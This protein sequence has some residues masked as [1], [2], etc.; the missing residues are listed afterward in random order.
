MNRSMPNNTGASQTISEIEHRRLLAEQFKASPQAGP[1]NLASQ[2]QQVQR[3]EQFDNLMQTTLNRFGS[4]SVNGSITSGSAAPSMN[5]GP[6]RHQQ[7]DLNASFK[8]VK[9][10]RSRQLRQQKNL[11]ASVRH[12]YRR[13]SGTTEAYKTSARKSTMALDLPPLS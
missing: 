6:N 11:G 8:P 2:M 7:N 13:K 12:V 3:E 9:L 10:N 5:R 4:D 1:G